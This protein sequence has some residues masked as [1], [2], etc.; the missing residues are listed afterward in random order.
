MKKPKKHGLLPAS[1][2]NKIVCITCNTVVE[3]GTCPYNQ[4]LEDME[5]YYKDRDLNGDEIVRIIAKSVK[6]CGGW[7]ISDMA[8][9]II[10]ARNRK[11]DEVMKEVT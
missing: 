1:N 8:K 7:V 10:T 9:D 4:G 3:K 2:I 6:N 5:A 11:R